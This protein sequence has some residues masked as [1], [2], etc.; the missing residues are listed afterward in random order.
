[1]RL[2]RLAI[3][4]LPIAALLAP[5]AAG[6]AGPDP[7]ARMAAAAAH[8]R[9]G[10]PRE[11]LKVL[12]GTAAVRKDPAGGQVIGLLRARAL[13]AMGDK[14]GAARA[15]ESL[16]AQPD[17]RLAPA[18]W[19]VAMRVA[20]QR[21]KTDRAR[22]A[23]E[24][25]LQSPELTPQIQA[26]A[27]VVRAWALSRSELDIDREAAQRLVDANVS[28]RKTRGWAPELLRILA[29]M[30]DG[31][32]RRGTL[33][34]L[35]VRYGASNAGRWAVRELPWTDLTSAEL[36]GRAR[37]L[38]RDRSYDMAAEALGHLAGGGVQPQEV[39]LTRARISMRM[40]EGY[41]EAVGWLSKVAA[42]GDKALADEAWFRLGISLG[43]LGRFDEAVDAMR[44][45]VK[46][47]PRGPF[48][49]EA[50]YQVGRLYH[51]AGQFERAIAEHQQ[52]LATKRPDM[53]KWR[54]FLGWSYFRARRLEDAR[55][56]FQGLAQRGSLLVGPKALYWT[57]RSYLLEGRRD[58]AEKHLAELIRRAPHSYY[59]LLGARLLSGGS[60]TPDID[61]PER[62]APLRVADVSPGDLIAY[63]AA[64]GNRKVA[65]ALQ[66][67]RLL[68][69][70]GFPE[71]A[72]PV[73]S[74]SSL[75][76]KL[77][78]LL[79]RKVARHPEDLLDRLLERHAE[80][81]KSRA[82]RR[83][84]WTE[85]FVTAT[86]E[87]RR[88]AYPPAWIEVA[89]AAGRVHAVDPWWLLSH[90]L[91]ESRYKRFARSHAGALG[92]M[93]ILPRTGRRIASRIRFPEHG[94][95]SVYLFEPGVSLRQA[96]WYLSTLTN[97]FHDRPLLAIAAYNGGPR[98]VAQHLSKRPGMAMDVLIEEI[99]AHE[100]RNYVRK[101][102]DHIA[103]YLA[104][105]A[106][107]P[108]R[109][110]M[111]LTLLR[112]RPTGP[113]RGIVRF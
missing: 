80:R 100:A 89:R 93:Q 79:G 75:G 101:V 68:V 57:A 88:E 112:P 33:K 71:L 65:R 64:A 61:L 32:E 62:D 96:A 25:L 10:N 37:A 90:M 1:M 43:H 21:E 41:E 94:D 31:R 63:E 9:V 17:P 111:L 3:L 83:L 52:F 113:P 109:R 66:R 15:I 70:A 5:S 39:L 108:E 45:Y 105:Y 4:F 35:S 110:R 28:V 67:V 72:G 81:W 23:A 6:A 7:W 73:A 82:P 60:G 98:L 47:A 107:E 84:P 104:L 97:E 69:A 56:V 78:K 42:G 58:E 48:A 86:P 53:D 26:E 18:I 76:P 102:V 20:R 29:T 13:L 50:A 19:L 49:L 91:Q 103:R 55:V 11:A 77:K 87:Q 44:I 24:Q 16:V 74:R 12:P 27:T 8:I 22:Y 36:L 99:G 38:F 85:G 92:P 51:E 106:P 2:S 40:R 59:G 30:Q 54:W 95:P 46:R 14:D 34:R